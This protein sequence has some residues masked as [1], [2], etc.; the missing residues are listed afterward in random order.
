MLARPQIGRKYSEFNPG[1]PQTKSKQHCLACRFDLPLF[2]ASN[3]RKAEYHRN[4]TFFEANFQTFKDFMLNYKLIKFYKDLE[5]FYLK[6]NH[7]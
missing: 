4:L 5:T 2:H 7:N 3:P 1:I 6:Y